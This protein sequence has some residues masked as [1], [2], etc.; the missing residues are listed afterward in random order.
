MCSAHASVVMMEVAFS[1]E[2]LFTIT[3]FESR[4]QKRKNPPKTAE[5]I[6]K[7]MHITI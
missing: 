1:E 6:M 2:L 5:I 7:Y 4:K 3:V